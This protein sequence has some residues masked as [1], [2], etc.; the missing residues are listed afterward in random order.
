VPVVIAVV[1]ASILYFTVLAVGLG[2][3]FGRQQVGE[4]QR[5]ALG[6]IERGDLLAEH[7]MI[8]EALASFS[9]AQ[10]LVPGLQIP[11]SSLNHVCIRGAVWG[12]HTEVM[13]ACEMAV[14]LAPNDDGMLFGRGLARALTGDMHG[15]IDDFEVYVEWTKDNGIY[16]PYG[17]E[18]EGF[19]LELKAGRN[20]FDEAQLD[21]WK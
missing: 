4:L 1:V 14:S 21:A 6:T 3:I 20:P 16:D 2:V 19:I 17:I 8:E 12:Y 15:A 18:V 9:E 5:E 10:Q 11:A 13:D 7:G